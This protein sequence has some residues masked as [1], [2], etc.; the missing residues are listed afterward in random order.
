MLAV[1]QGAE[2]LSSF[3]RLDDDSRTESDLDTA[4]LLR[5]ATRRPAP[6][7]FFPQLSAAVRRHCFSLTV[8]GLIPLACLWAE[9]CAAV[10]DFTW[11]SWATIVLTLE[12]LLLMAH[13]LPPDLVMVA[14]TVMLRMLGIITEEQAWRGFASQGV[15]AIGV[16]F[17]VAKCLE[18][19]GTIELLAGLFLRNTSSPRLAVWQ[20]C[21]PVMLVS[22]IVND[23][24]LVAMMIPIVVKWANNNALPVSWFLLPLS[25]SALLVRLFV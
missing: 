6:F 1:G 5:P 15:L 25:Y 20:L 11:Q 24:P 8:G 18:E 21:L 9:H 13:N 23:T 17:V 7:S 16:L 10:D 22:S 3:P 4:P 12:A 19:A 14:V 2:E